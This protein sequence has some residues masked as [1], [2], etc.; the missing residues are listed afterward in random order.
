MNQQS[1]TTTRQFNQGQDA[2]YLSRD[3]EI[4][5][6]QSY[7]QDGDRK[8]YNALF[9]SHMR[10]VHKIVQ[11][12][13]GYG[14]QQEDLH[15]EG[16]MGLMRAIEKFEPEKGFRLNTYAGW[17]IR[18]AVQ[19][20][21]LK[22][23]SLIKMGTTS[24][25]KTMFFNLNRI[26]KDI[27]KK[28]PQLN[29]FEVD[30]KVAEAF[31]RSVDEV[32]DMRF[33]MQPVLPL[34]APR[35][36]GEH[37][38]GEIQDSIADENADTPEETLVERDDADYKRYLLRKAFEAAD[39]KDREKDILRARRLAD[40]PKTLEDLSGVYGVTR[41]RIRQIEVRAFK[42]LE[43]AVLSLQKKDDGSAFAKR[44]RHIDRMRR[45]L[46]A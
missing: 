30:A 32:Q 31:G 34:N 27:T 21:I 19:S 5:L 29:D 15:Q 11:K 28:Y 25:Q 3:Q 12:Y 37:D 2:P 33:R 18:A 9:R 42:K 10:L 16:Y 35:K 39:L 17:W 38:S 23:I 40:P 36:N 46:V 22:D 20:H 8:A 4:E 6:M 45:P 14:L 24:V 1:E 44:Q 43:Q 26:T 41:E 13:K 7:Q